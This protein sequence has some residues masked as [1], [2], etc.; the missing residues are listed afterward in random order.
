[1]RSPETELRTSASD[2]QLV[3]GSFRDPS[4]YVFEYDG[5][6]YRQV[7]QTYRADYD[8][9]ST[10]GLYDALCR[11]EWLVPHEEVEVP[12]PFPDQR[13]RVIKPERVPLVSYPYEWCFG[14]LK[15]AALLTLRIQ[16]RALDFGMSL[17]D[18]SAYNVQFFGSRPVFIDTLSFERR[19]RE[20]PWPAYR[21]FCQHF[22]APLVLV[23][24]LDGR[25]GQLFRVFLDGV[26]LDTASKILG[27]RG[28]FRFGTL[29]H[30]HLHARTIRK[31]SRTHEHSGPQRTRTVSTANLGAMIDNLMAVVRRIEWKPRDSEWAGYYD[32]TNYSTVAEDHKAELVSRFIDSVRPATVWDFG[33]N[34]G[35]YTRLAASVATNIA[36]FDVD[37]AA[38]D[39]NYARC[40]ADDDPKLLPLVLDLTNPS[41]GLG[42]AGTE[43][44]S[45]VERGPAD[46]VMALAL[47]HHLT[48]ANNVPLD[49]VADFLA[50][51]CR[52]LIVEF[53]PKSDSQVRRLLASRRDIFD[54]YTPEGFESAFRR[55]FSI[56][57]KTPI[58]ESERAL[59]LMQVAS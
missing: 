7:N 55:R 16:R 25:L 36:A 26:P 23:G 44:M 27:G 2:G 28:W 32:D 53:V 11:S 34:T 17:K 58:A 21:Q 43:R 31:H 10:S 9:L 51:T 42:W 45:V 8:F 40:R 3:D 29:T 33:A 49:R 56:L 19:E 5:Q 1:M 46:L 39:A 52:W 47:V 54:S 13:Y 24:R 22:L 15:D 59:Y 41:P 57:E 20:E 50:R 35:R 37:P 48:I 6:I 14:Q 38:V 12:S 18:A 4:G 30:I